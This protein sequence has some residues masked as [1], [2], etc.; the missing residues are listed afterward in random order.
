MAGI[1]SLSTFSAL[2]HRSPVHRR[3]AAS[4][5]RRQP[6]CR[7][8]SRTSR[9]T[10]PLA[11]KIKVH[12]LRN[13]RQAEL[14]RQLEELKQE[15]GQLRVAKVTGGA[16]SKL[17]KMCVQT[18][19]PVPLG[20]SPRGFALA[21]TPIARGCSA[22]HCAA[23]KQCIL[24]Y[25]RPLRLQQGRAQVDRARA[26]GDP[27]EPQ[28]ASCPAQPVARVLD[29]LPTPASSRAT[30]RQARKWRCPRVTL[31]ERDLSQGRD[32]ST[33]VAAAAHAEIR[34]A[35]CALAQR[36]LGASAAPS[37]PFQGR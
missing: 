8:R 29:K 5:A 27:P 33:A 31:P 35:R 26:D 10:L 28:G 34:T 24:T 15:L 22:F 37:Q 2:P 12:E 18:P 30:E 13:R 6:R 19:A 36:A 20:S 7:G 1:R 11:A 23:R 21:G 14:K 16:A 32:V 4:S 17:A 9:A 3:P 25:C